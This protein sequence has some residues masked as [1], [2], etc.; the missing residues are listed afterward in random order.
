MLQRGRQGKPKASFLRGIPRNG[1][2]TDAEKNQTYRTF[3][4]FA[5]FGGGIDSGAGERTE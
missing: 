5:Y 3:V 4:Q 2:H 1:G